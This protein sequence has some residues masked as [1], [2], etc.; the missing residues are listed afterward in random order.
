MLK[1]THFT[2]PEVV[3]LLDA[4][5]ILSYPT[6]GGVQI[7]KAGI[8]GFGLTVPEAAADWGHKFAKMIAFPKDS[9]AT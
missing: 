2:G 9:P 6:G 8:I 5:A 1:P 3:A 4:P 7:E